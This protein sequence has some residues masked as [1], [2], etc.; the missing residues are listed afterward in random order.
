MVYTGV[1]GVMSAGLSG[2]HSTYLYCM[3][4]WFQAFLGKGGAV[5]GLNFTA[6]GKVQRNVFGLKLE[7]EEFVFFWRG[8]I[9]I[10][11]FC[12]VGVDYFIFMMNSF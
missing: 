4:T 10:H 12:E 5:V 11:P 2:F 9:N 1:D 3:D 7:I 6:D 8:A